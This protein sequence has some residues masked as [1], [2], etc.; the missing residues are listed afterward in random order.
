MK[1]EKPLL[2]EFF[3]YLAKP[4]VY[5]GEKPELKIILFNVVR[6]WAMIFLLS[7]FFALVSNFLLTEAG[8][9]DEDFAITE[10]FMGSSPLLLF[11]L[12]VIWAPI[13]EEI[14]FRLWLRFSPL[15]WAFGL[16]FLSLFVIPFFNLS[17]LTL[18]S[19]R[20]VLST[21]LFLLLLIFFLYRLFSYEKI[22]QKVP[23]FLQKNF[24]FLFYISS[25][26]FAVLHITNYDIDLKTIWHFA[27]ILIFPQ[28]F[29]SFTISFV[30][31]NYGFSWS[32]FMHA[33]NNF[34]AVSPFLFL[35]PI[36]ERIEDVSFENIE[37]LEIFSTGEMALI[38]G[39]LAFLFMVFTVC[40]WSV[41]S[42][43]F[44]VFK[45]R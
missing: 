41:F 11:F 27:P 14:A 26:A 2:K 10:I 33:L 36:L 38:I 3:R 34:V 1:K 8:Y 44:E 28:L 9:G 39:V 24:R 21:S 17:F 19:W 16:S 43:I 30:R 35:L 45:K 29:L 22:V 20:N 5:V 6:L 32:I 12:I 31:M 37:V 7:M 25:I 4:V 13:S 18:D 42:L 15:K 23:L 40:F